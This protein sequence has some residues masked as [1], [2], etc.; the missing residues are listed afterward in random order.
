MRRHSLSLAMLLALG[1]LTG[2]QPGS[3]PPV[4]NDQSEQTDGHDDHAGHAHPEHGPNGGELFE[5]GAEEYHAELLHDDASQ[6]VT[7]TLLDSAAVEPVTIP[8]SEVTLNVKTDQ[9]AAQFKLTATDEGDAHSTFTINDAELFKL[10]EAEHA[11]ITLVVTIKGKQY[12]GQ[13][14]HA[15]DHSHDH[16]H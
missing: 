9:G 4:D 8:E 2:C 5:L 13:M 14:H 7:I 3:A 16:E 12:R 6:S 11:D 15:H 10:L 1:L